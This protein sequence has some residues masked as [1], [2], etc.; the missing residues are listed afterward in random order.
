MAN[1]EEIF[2]NNLRKN[3]E[4]MRIVD[5]TG[6]VHEGNI[7]AFDPFCV[8]YESSPQGKQILIRKESIV[9]IEPVNA[10][11]RYILMNHEDRAEGA[12]HE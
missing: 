6:E 3:S 1:Y 7:I 11:A 5:A 9:Y 12:R 8:M 4:R 10:R 2:L